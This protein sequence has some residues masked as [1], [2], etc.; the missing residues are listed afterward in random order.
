MTAKLREA[1]TEALESIKAGGLIRR[2]S[3]VWTGRGSEAPR[4]V[5]WKAADASD[6]ALRRKSLRLPS[7]LVRHCRPLERPDRFAMPGK[8]ALLP[9]FG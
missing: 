3:L 6:E 7:P 8:P 2:Y 1:L 9:T 4:I 5:V